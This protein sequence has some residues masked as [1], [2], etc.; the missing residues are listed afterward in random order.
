[1]RD[2][3]ALDVP[4]AAAWKLSAHVAVFTNACAMRLAAIQDDPSTCSTKH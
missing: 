2:T 3:A 4:D 1:M